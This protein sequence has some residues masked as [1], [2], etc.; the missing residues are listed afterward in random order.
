MTGD[1]FVPVQGATMRMTGYSGGYQSPYCAPE[2]TYYDQTTTT[3]AGG[4]YQFT[5]P[6]WTWC[7]EL[8]F[9]PYMPGRTSPGGSLSAGLIRLR[10]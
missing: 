5:F 4:F 2:R 7:A 9:I 10:V 6:A 8:Q 1:W 3:D